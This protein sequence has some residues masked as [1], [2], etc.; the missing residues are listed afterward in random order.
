[1]IHHVSISAHDPKHVAEVLA[2][3]M[4]GRAYPFPGGIARS[5]MAV[6]EDGHGTLIEV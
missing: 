3:L 4:G 6:S 2:E 5:F 1:M